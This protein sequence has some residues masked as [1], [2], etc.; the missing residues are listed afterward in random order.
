MD[1]NLISDLIY[2]ANN[3][4]VIT[5]SEFITP[6][7]YKKITSKYMDINIYSFGIIRKIFAFVPNYIDDFEFPIKLLKIEVSNKFRVYTHRDFLGSIMGLNIKRELIGDIFVSD[8]IA[9]VYVMSDISDFIIHNLNKI[10]INNCTVEISDKTNLDFKY[11]DI[12]CIISSFRLDNIVSAITNQSR[13]NTELYIQQGLCMV[14]YEVCIDKS[15]L[16][17]ENTI[18]S[19]KK[20][21]RYIVGSEDRKTKKDKIVLNIKKFI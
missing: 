14:D 6:N 5:F 2:D 13:Q 10:G 21:G 3:L 17:Y 19:L 7:I 1:R 20:Y 16:I 4:G 15:K 18:L 9:Y 8:N 12:K 11:E